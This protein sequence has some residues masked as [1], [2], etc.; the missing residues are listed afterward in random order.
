MDMKLGRIAVGLVVLALVA[1]AKAQPPAEPTGVELELDAGEPREAPADVA[2]VA[3]AD[4]AEA[5]D[6]ADQPVVEDTR[7][8]PV[9]ESE[10]DAAP[11]DEAL[12]YHP[13]QINLNE[14]G[15][16]YIR[17]LTWA[18]IWLRAIENNPGTM[19]GGSPEN[20]SFDVGIRR[21]RLLIVAQPFPK[22]RFIYHMG[23]NNQSFQ[24]FRADFYIHDAYAEIDV[25]PGMLTLGGG[26]HYFNGVSRAANASTI[27]FL[28]LDASIANWF[29]LERTDQFARQ[30]GIFAHG[31]IAGLDYRVSL[32]RPFAP[33]TS[34]VMDGP[35]DYRP[36]ANTWGTAGYFQY[37]FMDHESGVLP[38]T[39]GTYYGSKT[40]FNVGAGYYWHP[41]ALGRLDAA[42]DEETFDQLAFGV[43]SFLE[44]PIADGS[45]TGYL[46]YA[47]H[48][49]GPDFVRNIGVMNLG[50]GGTSFNG[51]GNAYPVLGTGHHIFGQA[52]YLLP[53]TLGGVRFQPYVNVLAE[54]LEGLD[55]PSITLEGGVNWIVHGHSARIT[56]HFRSRPVFTP[57]GSVASRAS[58]G[59]LQ[60]QVFL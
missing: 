30:L 39:T 22:A 4:L 59:I 9:A 29:T 21:A 49:M 20:V 7:S 25:V 11:E 32:N 41:D 17:F 24:A 46:S 36:N 23:I 3:V 45:I 10:T 33:S 50:A 28:G 37:M 14:A 42:G 58:E 43:D 18:Q 34:L 8:E 2:D 12:S 13:A 60:L 16:Q 56:T 48:D 26:L 35:V 38:Y 54:A 52:G 6:V 5:A 51:P 55:D 19:V 40:V 44:Y 27:T 1:P 47:Y 57:G 53:W 15:T 31:Q